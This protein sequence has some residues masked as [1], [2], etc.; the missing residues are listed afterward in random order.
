MHL[1]SLALAFMATVATTFAQNQCP[2]QVKS[3]K[4]RGYHC[5]TN[6]VPNAKAGQRQSIGLS[7]GVTFQDCADS[8]YY[9]AACKSLLYTNNDK[10]CRTY[11]ASGKKMGLVANP[12]Q[13]SHFYNMVSA[14]ALSNP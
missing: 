10:G 4:P 7:T 11:K 13:P 5:G 8:C 3:P 1:P 14:S 6:M 12:G 9:T 2:V